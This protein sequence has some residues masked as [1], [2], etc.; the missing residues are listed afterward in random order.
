ML[1]MLVIWLIFFSKTLKWKNFYFVEE[2]VFSQIYHEKGPLK[3]SEIAIFTL[4]IIILGWK[5]ATMD[6]TL[7]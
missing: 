5:S 2:I 6:R 4:Q 7:S 3:P 1:L